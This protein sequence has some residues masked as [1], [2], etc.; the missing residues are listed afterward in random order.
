M[1]A[2]KPF[3]KINK[4]TS[5]YFRTSVLSEVPRFEFQ[6][7]SFLD[8]LRVDFFTC[9]M[10]GLFPASPDYSGNEGI[11]ERRSRLEAGI[12]SRAEAGGIV[13]NSCFPDI[14]LQIL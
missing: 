6:L 5:Y 3:K 4:C 12:Q 2:I 13:L 14:C 9:T 7:H 8:S 1:S 10:G 11:S